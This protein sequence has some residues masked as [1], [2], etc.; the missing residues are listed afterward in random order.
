M[1]NQITTS[2]VNELLVVDIELVNLAFSHSD[3]LGV[4]ALGNSVDSF[5]TLLESDVGPFINGMNLEYRSY[6][7]GMLQGINEKYL[8]AS[9]A[10]L[11]LNIQQ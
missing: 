2:F 11:M 1:S 10:Y 7:V 3:K 6:I 9:M 4:S 5:R 8:E